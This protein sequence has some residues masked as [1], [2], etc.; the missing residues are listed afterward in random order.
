MATRL[1]KRMRA[2]A[3]YEE[4]TERERYLV[5]RFLARAERFQSLMAQAVDGHGLAHIDIGG[6]TVTEPADVVLTAVGLRVR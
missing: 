2:S 4:L 1:R 5:D 6:R 3:G